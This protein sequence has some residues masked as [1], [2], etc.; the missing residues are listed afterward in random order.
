MTTPIKVEVGR[1]T[2][3]VLQLN[4]FAFRTKKGIF[5]ISGTNVDGTDEWREVGTNNFHTWSRES[6]REWH[7]KEKIEPIQESYTIEKA[8]NIKHNRFK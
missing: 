4:I 7:E 3:T 2:I 8:I 5:R 1:K 6:I